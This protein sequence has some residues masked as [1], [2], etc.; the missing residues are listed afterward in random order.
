MGTVKDVLDAC[1]KLTPEEQAE[2]RAELMRMDDDGWD[3]KMKADAAAD[4]L[5]FLFEDA[6]RAYKAGEINFR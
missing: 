1:K 3:R 2:V 4:K 5:D 6:E